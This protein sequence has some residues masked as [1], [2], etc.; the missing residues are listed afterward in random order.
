VFLPY[1]QPEETES[2]LLGCP[3]VLT[4]RICSLPSAPGGC[5]RLPALADPPFCG[6]K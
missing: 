2:L 6:D 1:A 5:L 3:Q 4:Q